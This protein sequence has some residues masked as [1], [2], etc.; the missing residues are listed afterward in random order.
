MTI[1]LESC[2]CFG[3]NEKQNPSFSLWLQRPRIAEH[4]S[5]YG[6]AGILM[7]ILCPGPPSPHIRPSLICDSDITSLLMRILF[8]PIKS[9]DARLSHCHQ[10]YNSVESYEI[11]LGSMSYTSMGMHSYSNNSKGQALPPA[12]DRL[13]PWELYCL[14]LCLFATS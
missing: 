3:K 2:S 12:M 7:S 5:G 9:W 11:H 4:P 1:I 14:V 13:G 8:D 6:Y 10:K